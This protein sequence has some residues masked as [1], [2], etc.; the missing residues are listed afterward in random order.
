MNRA[1]D[2]LSA[3]KREIYN[4]PLER[5]NQFPA[6]QA[7][8]C[9]LADTPD[10]GAN[11]IRPKANEGFAEAIFLDDSQRTQVSKSNWTNSKTG[12]V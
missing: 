1:E 11:R 7:G 6:V 5:R 10:T 8:V 2:S 12:P 9:L 4:R 3:G